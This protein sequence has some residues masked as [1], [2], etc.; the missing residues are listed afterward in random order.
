MWCFLDN[1]APLSQTIA[2]CKKIHSYL[3]ML[4]V[5]LC[6]GVIIMAAW[7]SHIGVKAT[8][9]EDITST[10]QS[11]LF[12]PNYVTIPLSDSA[13]LAFLAQLLGRAIVD[14]S[15]QL[16]GFINSCAYLGGQTILM[17]FVGQAALYRS[18]NHVGW[19]LPSAFFGLWCSLIA[20]TYY[21]AAPVLPT[22]QGTNSTLILL[23]YWLRKEKFD[24]LNDGDNEC[25]T[26]FNFIVIYT[27]F[28][29]LMIAIMGSGTML[30]FIVSLRRYRDS[31]YT[32]IKVPK[33]GWA[34]FWMTI[35]MM[36]SYIGA[37]VGKMVTS[38]TSLDAIRDFNGFN[39]DTTFNKN[40]L[41]YYDNIYYPFGSGVINLSSILWACV[42][43]SVTRAFFNSRLA[44]YKSCALASLL[45]A[46]T[47]Y[48]SM[49]YLMTT[50]YELSLDKNDVCNNYFKQPENAA[51]YGYPSDGQ[52]KAYCSG[53]RMTA[54]LGL[55][56]FIE[57]NLMFFLSLYVYFVNNGDEDNFSYMDE[58]TGNLS[59]TNDNSNKSS[60][61]KSLLKV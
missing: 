35:I 3:I 10:W 30:A 55:A 24:N 12:S 8:R 33:G 27:T 58:K 20:G 41:L 47:N 9:Y 54:F 19:I 43:M 46:L 31:S 5:P 13:Q 6:F 1:D 21:T 23:M 51:S 48:S 49:V 59:I 60:L 52:S 18:W 38:I 32:P 42:F 44:P 36:F 34:V 14:K 61:K 25:D 22:P 39:D 15:V 53:F 28:M 45:Y 16:A 40:N 2:T 57:M 56:L 11:C 17:T 37:F 26:A 4:W 50:Y 7:M 29:V